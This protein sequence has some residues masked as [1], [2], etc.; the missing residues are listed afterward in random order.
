MGLKGKLTRLENRLG[1][2]RCPH[3]GGALPPRPGD[4]ADYVS[5]TE[6][7]RRGIVCRALARLFDREQLLDL[8][9]RLQPALRAQVADVYP[10]SGGGAEVTGRGG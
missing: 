1:L 8:L 2:E 3:C 10:L 6:E 4:E 5:M 7:Q 9:A